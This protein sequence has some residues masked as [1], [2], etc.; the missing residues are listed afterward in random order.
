MCYLIADT[1]K[2][3]YFG[4][5]RGIVMVKEKAKKEEPKKSTVTTKENTNKKKNVKKSKKAVKE[6]SFKSEFKKIKW[7][8]KKDMIKYSIATIAFVIFFA[9]FFYLI[10][11]IQIICYTTKVEV[12]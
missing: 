1:D 12:N 2:C 8:S 4:K 9:I 7:P 5:M 10:E 6:L 11:L 3:F